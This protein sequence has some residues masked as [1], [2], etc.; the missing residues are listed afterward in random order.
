MI[1]RDEARTRIAAHVTR[2]MAENN[3][4]QIELAR[5]SCV[6]HQRLSLLI[7]GE[8]LPNPADLWNVA[9]ALGTTLDGLLSPVDGSASKN[10]CK[11]SR[12]VPVAN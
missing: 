7:R 8:L 11:N 12:R 5:M 6:A 2:L 4:S 3:I 9:E 1:T 10:S